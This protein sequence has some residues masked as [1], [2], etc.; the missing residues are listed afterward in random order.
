MVVKK[1]MIPKQLQIALA[2]KLLEKKGIPT[3]AIDFELEI[4]S[5]LSFEENIKQLSRRLGIDLTPK[6]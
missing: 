4:D 3:N 5:H 1:K 2:K 6:P